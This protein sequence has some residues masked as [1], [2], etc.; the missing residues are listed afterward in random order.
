MKT[1]FTFFII[2]LALAV[3]SAFSQEAQIK[4]EQYT[5]DIE[6]SID[7]EDDLD[8]DFNQTFQEIFDMFKQNTDLSKEV[9]LKF[10]IKDIKKKKSNVS[11]S[12]VSFKVS[13]PG[14]ECDALQKE[15]IKRVGRIKEMITKLTE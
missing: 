7:A 15:A 13:G 4:E 1:R 6:I 5:S 2:V 11:V 14:S 9:S 10:T 3:T 8:Q 12:N